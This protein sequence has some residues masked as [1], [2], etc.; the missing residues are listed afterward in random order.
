MKDYAGK[1]DRDLLVEIYTDM[2]TITGIVENHEGQL[3]ELKTDQNKAKGG[4]AVAG[5][6]ISGILGRLVG[7]F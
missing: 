6:A 5:V 7:L 2:Q 1:S 4:L 3:D